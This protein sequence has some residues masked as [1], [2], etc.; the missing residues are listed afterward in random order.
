MKVVKVK[1]NYYLENEETKIK[2]EPEVVHKYRLY[3][4]S[5]V[6][7]LELVI[8][9]NQYYFYYKMA[10]KRLSSMQSEYMLRKYLIEKV[11][12]NQF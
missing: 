3:S 5:E 8:L 6:A 10:L 2:L 4:S 9:D 1:T 12:Q 7:N 11:F